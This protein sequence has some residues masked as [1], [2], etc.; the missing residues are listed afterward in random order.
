MFSKAVFEIGAESY[1]AAGLVFGGLEDVDTV[2]DRLLKECFFSMC[3]RK[4][5][6]KV[7]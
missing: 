2:H 1:V 3:N 7:A 5:G 4:F 6:W